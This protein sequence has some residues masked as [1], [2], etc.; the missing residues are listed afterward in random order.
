MF[1]LLKYEKKAAPLKSTII[2]K[3]PDNFQLLHVSYHPLT[4]FFLQMAHFAISLLVTQPHEIG[5]FNVQI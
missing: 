1:K 3:F 4:K 2:N 5:Y